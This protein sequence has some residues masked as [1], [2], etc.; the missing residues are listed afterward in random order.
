ML[1]KSFVS[2]F[3]AV[4]AAGSASSSAW[5]SFCLSLAKRRKKK[6]FLAQPVKH[7]H[8]GFWRCRSGSP[9]PSRLPIERS[10][11]KYNLQSL[12][13]TNSRWPCRRR[14]RIGGE[15][16]KN[17]ARCGFAGWF[18]SLFCSS[19]RSTKLGHCVSYLR[20]AEAGSDASLQ[21]PSASAVLWANKAT[22]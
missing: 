2:L 22:S 6:A 12:R 20:L 1:P 3:Q 5:H 13:A 19:C 16:K 15:K 17:R 11:G 18:I 14:T 8:P 21:R 4:D 10:M 9:S 7:H